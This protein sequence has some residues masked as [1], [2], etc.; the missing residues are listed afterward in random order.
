M[1][2]LSLEQ[3]VAKQLPP[4]TQ[5]VLVAVS[6]GVDSVVLLHLLRAVSAK[7][8]FSIHV[9]HLDHQIRADS[10]ADAGFVRTLCQDWDIPC[11][12]ELCD[13]RRL[14]DREKISLEMAGRQARRVFLQRLASEVGAGMIALAH[15]RDDQVETFLLR[16]LRGSGQSGLA[17]MQVCQGN[18]WRP[19]LT[20]GRQEILAYADKY[21][22]EWVE[23]ESNTDPVFLRN[24]L[25]TQIIPQ[26]HEIN[27]R[28]SN[29]MVRL[30]QQFR[31]DEDYWAQEVEQTFDALVVSR[32]DGLRLS[33]S[34]LLACH[35]ALRS[36]LVREALSQVRGHLQHIEFVHL[37]AIDTLIAA[38]KSQAELNLPDCWVA[39]RYDTLW[40]RRAAPVQPKPFDLVV[41]GNGELTLPDGRILRTSIRTEQEGE[42]AMAV[43]FSL[44]ALSEPLRVRSW[45]PG[46]R[47][48]PAGFAGHKRLKRL[49]SDL[50]VEHEVRLT[51]P[52]L[53]SGETILWVGGI[54][55]SRHAV[56]GCDTGEILRVELF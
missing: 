19:L 30:I 1:D 29:G 45:L 18:W 49:F 28:F 52:L 41:P 7:S 40:L 43:E 4:G 47:F 44:A 25:R 37:R 23:D 5:K 11:T 53:V 22:L 48:A 42:S 24:R 36:R 26:L 31:Q 15:H 9:G 13:V 56:A 54:R 46:D 35:P 27:P 12:I 51:T 14:A 33:R 6:G 50:R 3:S 34:K 10:S 8:G 21:Q 2:L 38:P 20:C 55:R 32:E 16:L 39:R 17:A